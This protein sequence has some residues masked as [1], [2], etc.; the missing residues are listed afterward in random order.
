MVGRAC[1]SCIFCKIKTIGIQKRGG[2]Q[3]R[4][5]GKLWG[6]SEFQPDLEVLLALV[7][8]EINLER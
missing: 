1:V 6:G 4:E 5:Q 8:K 3:A 2:P 7:R